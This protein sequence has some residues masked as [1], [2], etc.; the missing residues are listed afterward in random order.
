MMN[1]SKQIGLVIRLACVVLCA[2]VL[3]TA[4]GKW[5]VRNDADNTEEV[6]QETA[7]EATIESE[8]IQDATEEA[9]EEATEPEETEPEETE[10]EET[11]G[12]S[13]SSTPGGQ[14]G[15]TG[16]TVP[17][18][19]DSDDDNTTQKPEEVLEVDQPGTQNN[20][21]TEYLNRE[22]EEISV[23]SVM[24]P[25]E[26]SIYYNFYNVEGLVLDIEDA[27]AYVIHNGVTHG[28][29]ANGRVQ[30]KMIVEGEDVPAAIQLG[31]TS[32]SEKLYTLRFAY[33]LGTAGNPEEITDLSAITVT[34]NAENAEGYFYSWT[35]AYDCTLELS[36]EAIQPE[37]V[38][39]ELT[40][41]VGENIYKSSE[42]ADGKLAIE[43]KANEEAIIQVQV[44]PEG[45]EAEILLSGSVTGAPGSVNNPYEEHMADRT[46]FETVEIPAEA[47]VHYNVYDVGGMTLTIENTDAYVVYDNVTYGADEKGIVT[48]RIPVAEE[49]GAP[50]ELIFGNLKDEAMSYIVSFSYPMGGA[51]EP[52]ELQTLESITAS[53]TAGFD[54]YHFGWT[55]TETG[56]MTITVDSVKNLTDSSVD[57]DYDI[58]ISNLTK[59]SSMTLG[60]D[61][62]MNGFDQATVSNL[63]ELG[64]EIRII[65]TVEEDENKVGSMPTVASVSA[66]GTVHGYSENEFYMS[67]E[68]VK[69]PVANWCQVYSYTR[70]GEQILTI[71]NAHD[72]TLVVGNKTYTANAN[73]VISMITPEANPNSPVMMELSS[74]SQSAKT[75]TLVFEYPLGHMFNPDKIQAG[76]T[77]VSIPKGSD[78]GY[79]YSWTAEENGVLTLAVAEE[80]WSSVN[81]TMTSQLT[82]DSVNLWQWSN[83]A[84][85]DVASSPLTMNVTAGEEI[86]INLISRS[87]RFPA[88]NLP[89][90]LSFEAELGA[91]SRPIALDALEGNLS[92]PAGK[93]MYYAAEADAMVLKV[94]GA[95]L[96][97]IY[98]GQS[99]AAENGAAEVTVYAG[100]DGKV[101]FGISNTGSAAAEYTYGFAAPLGHEQNPEVLESL[102][103]LMVQIPAG[104][105]SYY[106][107]WTADETGMLTFAVSSTQIPSGAAYDITIRNLNK[108]I[109]TKL[110]ADGSVNA[111]EEAIVSNLVEAEDQ[112]LICVSVTNANA[113]SKLEISGEIY[114]NE[115]NK[116][117]ISS[118][119]VK[120][121]VAAWCDFYAYNMVGGQILTIENAQDMTI[122]VNGKDYRAN[123]NGV[124]TLNTPEANPRNPV[125]IYITTESEEVKTY[126]L[127]F[128]YPVGHMYNP[129][130]ITVPNQ[131]NV[132]VPAGSEFGYNYVWTAETDG[133]L[134]IVMS[135][136]N[137]IEVTL[138]SELTNDNTYLWQDGVAQ[139]PL[140][141]NVTAGEVININVMSNSSSRPAVKANMNVSFEA[142]QSVA[143]MAMIEEDPL[144]SEENPEEILKVKDM[145]K[146]EVTIEE[147]TEGYF[148]TW[149]AKK[150]GTLTFSI[151]EDEE[152]PIPEDMRVNIKLTNMRTEESVELW[153]F[154]EKDEV[155]TELESITLNV[156]KWDEVL[157]QVTV[158]T[159]VD[160]YD[161]D[162]II[163]CLE[164][165]VMITGLFVREEEEV[166]PVAVEAVQPSEE[167]APV[168]EV[169]VPTE[170][171]QTPAVDEPVV[172]PEAIEEP[173]KEEEVP[174]A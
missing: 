86:H 126:D 25:G 72:L 121:T 157:I 148:Y 167:S 128:A 32:G 50:A 127:V 145:E 170:E 76:V 150:N 23:N 132:S 39:C 80:Y 119:D 38:T 87:T 144:G 34:M 156:N 89:I 84:G 22:E 55:A 109:E 108:E 85:A 140:T 147:G 122:T 105:E 104:S 78:E 141:L 1:T 97:V 98:N 114:G 69:I 120:V 20:S 53:V 65:I 46:S 3:L 58:T 5:G 40:V 10:P 110:S 112:V 31:N 96:S 68:T 106:Y 102:E 133:T 161:K 164:A 45:A 152:D 115:D 27:D 60:A 166:A 153:N 51:D 165:E 131:F 93:T 7:G 136:V 174:L 49:E 12:P 66:T 123:A 15:F 61:G 21:Y 44:M 70:I 26:S 2:L 173:L 163:S 160:T 91:Q 146:M 8:Q 29:D 124:I 118:N 75:Y 13:G 64:D 154:D 116:Y 62:W 57:V 4:C 103:A 37:D 88:V 28:P 71:E 143:V 24:I 17:D 33:P 149:T 155:W 42:S 59:E 83:E 151:L 168:E 169:V 52:E 77:N 54:G 159:P 82:Y 129:Q 18:T 137:K 41:T 47:Y 111:R 135:N 162:A 43:M 139:N 79:N 73:G 74:T 107:S 130:V 117:P 94:E 99:Y 90:T 171:V 138:T 125:E 56:V 100:V 158:T 63:V 14:G 172:E 19:G 113:D 35:A 101:I 92:V 95:A 36:V 16:A 134:S 67:A 142:A 30:V 81:V 6:L 9:T 48:F 11:T